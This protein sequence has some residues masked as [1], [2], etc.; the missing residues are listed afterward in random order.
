MNIRGTF[1]LL[2]LAVAA[3]SS[4]QG[5]V[6][7]RSVPTPMVLTNSPEEIKTTGNYAWGLGSARSLKSYLGTNELDESQIVK[8][9][10]DGLHGKTADGKTNLL[11]DKEVN[12]WFS[13]LRELGTVNR[14]KEA[15]AW[16]AENK[17][18]AGVVA[19]PSGLQ[20]KLIKEGNGA[21]P[22][23]TD[24]VLVNYRGT[25]IDGTEFDS[26]LTRGKPANMNLKSVVP[27]WTEALKLMREGGKI[28]AYIPPGLGYG[29]RARGKKLPANSVLIFDI[30]L[31]Q[32][33]NAP[34]PVMLKGGIPSTPP[35]QQPVTGPAQLPAPRAVSPVIKVSPDGKVET[36]PD[37]PVAPPPAPPA[38]K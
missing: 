19:L 3:A 10:L 8:G 21:T 31:I 24:N 22:T 20:Y 9:I 37:A 25:L 4:S 29:T 18:K 11:S 17:K 2:T 6:P 14:G 5:Q 13:K 27:G 26:T 16:M 33:T 34:P 12:D 28:T 35:N 30:E 1:R 15:D 36:V 23:D 38:P 7:V 32:I